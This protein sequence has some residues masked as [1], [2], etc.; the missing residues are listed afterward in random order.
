VTA[1]RLAWSLWACCVALAAVSLVFL[2]LNGSTTHSNTIGEPLVDALF[3]LIYLV[4]PSVGL[5]IALRQ[6]HNAI[7]WLFLAGGL[8]A[9]VE[10]AALGY[11]TYALLKEPGSLPGG[12]AAGLIADVVWV[13][14]MAAG[15]SL[16]LLL[17]PD[18]RPPSRRWN[19]LIWVVALA[20]VVYVAGTLLNPGPLYFFE[21]VRNPLGLEGA[22][23]VIGPVVN[24]VGGPFL[25]TTVAAAGALV[26]RFRR[27]RGVEREQLKWL[28]YTGTV[29]VAL[30][31]VMVLTGE[32][33]TEVAGLLVSDFFYGLTIAAIPLAIGAAIL[34]HRLYDIDVVIRRTVVYGA[35]TVTLAAAYTGCVL[36]LQL[37]LG[38][39]TED[40][41]LAIAGSTLAAAAL[42]RPALRRIRALVDRRFYRRRYDATQTIESF[43]AR[44]RDEVELDS[45]S[46]DLRGVVAETMQPA[47]VSLW[48]R[49]A[50]P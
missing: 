20:V 26:L 15:I 35:L 49:E 45:L 38:P 25:L 34:R 37:A 27:S 29:L 23:D 46:A 1:R 2:A 18:G 4:F 47:H 11:A 32:A 43:G 22:G 28:V 19:V 33:E 41:D 44:L 48:L 17:F 31:P 24:F 39:L 7:G 8:G 16:L 10:D 30:T 40:N 36:L 12:P 50:R 9:Q 5:A 3:G 13:P 42:V 6:P 14:T 21:D